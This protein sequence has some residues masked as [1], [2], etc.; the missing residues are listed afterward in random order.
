VL[1]SGSRETGLAG[2]PLIEAALPN[3][4]HPAYDLEGALVG[5]T[6]LYSTHDNRALVVPVEA[7]LAELGGGP[8]QEPSRGLTASPFARLMPA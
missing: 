4:H 6:R 2:V 7:A 1:G 3:N 5:F 8:R